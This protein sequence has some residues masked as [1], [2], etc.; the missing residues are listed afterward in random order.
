MEPVPK[1]SCLIAAYNVER[2]IER[3]IE[4]ALA[5]D[6]PA[7]RLEVIV[8]NDGSTDGTEAAI[9]PYRDRIRYIEKEN[10]GLVS[11]TNAGLAIAT[12]D[13][14]C[15]L[16]GDDTWPVDRLRR[17]VPVLQSRPELGLLHGDM[18]IVD[19]EGAVLHPS[20]FAHKQMAPP[21]GRVLGNLMHGNFVS[22]GGI[23]VRAALRDRFYPISEAC[24]YQDWYIA[25]R[26]AEVAEIDHVDFSVYHYRFHGGNESLGA[27]GDAFVAAIRRDVPWLLWMQRN[28][29]TSRVPV[30]ELVKAHQI[31]LANA[32]GVASHTGVAI[33]DLMPRVG[34]AEHA[35]AATESAHAAEAL[36]GG[37][38]EEAIRAWLRA[39]AAN[40]FDDLGRASLARALDQYARIP[41]IDARSFRILAFAD[42][43]LDA[44]E[45]L[46]AYGETFGEG[47]D[48]TLV[49]QAPEQGVEQVTEGLAAASAG[50]SA[51]LLLH[52]CDDPA[53][54]LAAGLGAVYTR[55][56]SSAPFDSVPHVAEQELA[57]VRA[58]AVR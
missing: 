35:L 51:D 46:A 31:L 57:A 20:F 12:G 25:S 41:R 53:V 8:I 54:L 58:L 26:V 27:T 22:A 34:D 47:D 11:A 43:L 6:W 30:E 16:D 15:F 2:W 50:A 52:P 28:L 40:P 42:E 14:I 17:Q 10:G 23:L 56:S 7:D 49:I 19:E 9:A 55:R 24:P 48:V 36:A 5:Q 38:V 44:P 32:H 33:A 1:V 37:R 18:T 4:S 3:S 21:R 13:L 29:D 45:M 39:L